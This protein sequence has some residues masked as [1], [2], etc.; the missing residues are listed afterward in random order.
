MTSAAKPLERYVSFKNIDCA[1]K[2]QRVIDRLQPRIDAGTNPYW[3]YFEKQR[4]SAL[5]QG[6]DDLRVL[7]SYLPTIR[8][9]LAD[10]EDTRTLAL[11]EDLEETCM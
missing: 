2:A 8:E 10:D 3:A 9:I 5:Q 7:H 6:F 11:L 4:A 1:G